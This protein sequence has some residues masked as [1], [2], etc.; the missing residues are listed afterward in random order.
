MWSAK[1]LATVSF[2]WTATKSRHWNHWKSSVKIVMV[3]ASLTESCVA[4]M[5]HF[6][7]LTISVDPNCI[8]DCLLCHVSVWTILVMWWPSCLVSLATSCLDLWLWP[9]SLVQWNSPL[10]LGGWW[11]DWF[12]LL[13]KHCLLQQEQLMMV[14]LLWDSRHIHEVMGNLCLWLH[15]N[16]S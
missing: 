1:N 3:V 14:H 2:D 13:W 11:A 7:T 10:T 5:H 4:W 6:S 12:S 16:W 8:L 9:C 15:L